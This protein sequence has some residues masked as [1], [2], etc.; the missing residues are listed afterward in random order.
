ML[1]PLVQ[2]TDMNRKERKQ[3]LRKYGEFKNTGSEYVYVIHA[4]REN[5]KKIPGENFDAF[6]LKCVKQLKTVTNEL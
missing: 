6:Y 4:T 5:I 1:P 3:L 2:Y